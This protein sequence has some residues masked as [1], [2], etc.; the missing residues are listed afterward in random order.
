MINAG[1]SDSVQIWQ[2]QLFANDF[3]PVCAM[4]GLPAE[5]WR[6][7]TFV[8]V[9]GW[10]YLMLVLVCTGVGI[11]PIYL[12]MRLVARTATGHLPLTNESSRTIRRANS[13]GALF[14]VLMFVLWA[15][16]IAILSTSRFGDTTANTLAV[17]AFVGGFIAGLAGVVYWLLVKPRFGPGGKV[18][19]AE[20][21]NSDRIV[22]LQRVHPL[23]VSA[24]QERQLNRSAGSL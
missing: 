19:Q 3:P 21:F 1:R 10:A 2:S 17:V 7:F 18:M 5:T 24:V 11:L 8:T 23:F 4:T 14:L 22:E 12:V 20:R 9:P 13:A 6:K 16:G 15:V